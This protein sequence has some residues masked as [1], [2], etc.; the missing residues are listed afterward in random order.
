M[1]TQHKARRIPL[2]WGL[3]LVVLVLAVFWLAVPR[4]GQRVTTAT[5]YRGVL[6][7]DLSTTGVVE[8]TVSDVASV[9]T[10]RVT[11]L[12]AQ[13]GDTVTR[14]QVLARLDTADLRAAVQE[15]Q[16]ALT[17]AQAQVA[18]LQ[19]TAASEAQQYRARIEEA[20]AGLQAARARLAQVS[21]GAREE[22][23]AA[24]RAAVEGARI[25]VAAAHLEYER[26]EQLLAAGAI[27]RQHR[28]SA[29][30]AA[31]TA[32]A[33]LEAERQALRRLEAGPREE[34]I[35]PARAQ[36]QAAEAALRQAEAT[37]TLI[38]ARHEEIAAAQAA[39]ARA[40]AAL[41]AARAQLSHASVRSP[42]T[43]VVSRKHLEVGEVA[44]P[45]EPLYSL[46]SLA[47]VWV[48]AEVDAGDVA[49]VAVGQRVTISLDA[50]PGRS[51]GGVV[52]RVS[53][54]AEPKAV[55]RV[56]AKVIR[57][58]V[59]VLQS[60]IPLRPGLEVNVTGSLPVGAPA[61]LVPNDAILHE[62]EEDQVY[63][64]QDGQ[65]WLR[66]VELGQSNFT[67]SQVLSGL[68]E[69]DVVAV[70]NLDQLSDGVRVRVRR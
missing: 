30:A 44:N 62:G 2:W 46:A 41:D 36:V 32:A 33:K 51:A 21:V 11:A 60:T 61:L 1:A 64:V 14:G 59:K 15:R 8:G 68:T 52:V 6:P 12:Y 7:L 16:A 39:A 10:A 42:L 18:A 47:E 50:Y 37:Q 27:S 48:V 17:A 34:D 25:Q 49:A 66:P 57:T 20:R 70:G 24:Q 29:Q 43:G 31:D 67:H 23:M 9:L 56:R 53:E 69:G 45:Y 55:G 4:Q 28:D 26:A 3:V 5:V 38:R 35:A 54:V 63:M 19:R 65:A 13:E 58:H 40:R 22:D